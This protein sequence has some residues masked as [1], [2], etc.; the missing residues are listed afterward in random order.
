MPILIAKIAE[1]GLATMLLAQSVAGLRNANSLP[2]NAPIS[3]DT[4]A[5]GTLL[6][7]ALEKWPVYL[8]DRLLPRHLD[9]IYKINK[10]FLHKVDYIWNGNVDKLRAMSIFEE[11]EAK[12]VRM[13]NLSIIGSHSINGVSH[14]HS[15]LIKS[16]LVPDFY[17]LWPEKFNNKTNGI[18]QRRWLLNAN[19]ELAQFITSKIG[20]RWITDLSRLRDLEPYST[21]ENYQGQINEIKTK[22]K[23]RLANYIKKELDLTL[24]TDSIFDIQIKRIHEYKRQLLNVLNIVHLYLRIIGTQTLIETPLPLMSAFFFMVSIQLLLMGLVAEMLT[25]IYFET[26]N[27]PIY[28]IRN[29]I[30]L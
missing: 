12:Y 6:P 3:P 9:I 20:D 2:L 4:T 25:R 14:M 15:E 27:K 18:T 8:I 30:N 1:L 7:E 16:K 28:N 21:D 5:I 24:S 10:H 29:K 13:A 26:L 11:S 19:P 22:N 17:Q 23:L